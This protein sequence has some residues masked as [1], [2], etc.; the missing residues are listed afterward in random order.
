MRQIY[1]YVYSIYIDCTCVQSE[2]WR[3]RRGPHN[4]R[5]RQRRGQP[6]RRRS[7]A[8]IDGDLSMP[9]THTLAHTHTPTHIHLYSH[10]H[11]YTHTSLPRKAH[12]SNLPL[13]FI[14]NAAFYIIRIKRATK[15]ILN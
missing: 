7:L 13:N 2:R 9:D 3:R 4:L 8:L 15:R 5:L 11:T 6:R 1:G 12:T 14:F 10:T